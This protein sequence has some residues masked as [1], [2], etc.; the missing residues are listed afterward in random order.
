MNVCGGRIWM[1]PRQRLQRSLTVAGSRLL[2]NKEVID[3]SKVENSLIMTLIIGVKQHVNNLSL[4]PVPV[5]LQILT[6]LIL[7]RAFLL[8]PHL[9]RTNLKD[10][11][12]GKEL[13]VLQAVTAA[14]VIKRQL[15]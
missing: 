1:N 15:K 4:A 12:G 6:C 8:S 2:H 14:E 11:G 5:T 3:S 7:K 13:K 9:Q 10:R